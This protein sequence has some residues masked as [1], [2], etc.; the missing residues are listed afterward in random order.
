MMIV[1]PVY[2]SRAGGAPSTV[3]CFHC[4]V[5]RAANEIRE[6]GH[7]TPEEVH[8]SLEACVIESF[9]AMGEAGHDT[10]KLVLDFVKTLPEQLEVARAQRPGADHAAGHA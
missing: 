9:V 6:A 8:Q 2:L 7:L 1:K 10:D 3:G 5:M 4:A